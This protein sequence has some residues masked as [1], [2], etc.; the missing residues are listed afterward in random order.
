MKSFHLPKI[1]YIKKFDK[2]MIIPVIDDDYNPLIEKL[3]RNNI[4][5][6]ENMHLIKWR[7][8]WIFGNSNFSKWQITTPQ[9]T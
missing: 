5:P 4:N 7:E 9:L 1:N 3:P 2:N 8:V 6:P